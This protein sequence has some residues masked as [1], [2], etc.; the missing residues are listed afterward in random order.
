MSALRSKSYGPSSLP[1]PAAMIVGGMLILLAAVGGWIAADK[2]IADPVVV[3]DEPPLT[4]RTGA[5]E[6]QLRPGWKPEAAL[7][8]L[9]GI[10]EVPGAKALAPTDGSSGRMV[11]ATLPT[12]EVGELPKATVEALRVPLGSS[13]RT[14]VAG[15]RGVG[16]TAL[17]LRGVTAGLADIYTVPTA[18]GVLAVGCVAPIDDPLPVGSCP[19]DIRAIAARQAPPDPAAALKAKLPA[20]MTR[21]NA[22]RAKARS[23]LRAA[24]TAP[25]QA[26]P[27]RR[28]WRA[29]KA[30]AKTL[31]PAAPASGPAAGLPDAFRDAARAYRGLALAAAHHDKRAW[32]RARA[33]V[34]AAEK[35]VAA[36]VNAV[37]NS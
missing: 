36:R 27:A 22:R 18:A 31:A 8:K 4:V 37:R 26:R 2:L 29:Y 1:S 16:Y 11:V 6:L 17:A 9:P 19:G 20:V 25:T 23:A 28:L 5:T 32:T 21:L 13:K 15:V 30:A 14:T 10:A 34:T 35:V 3:P 33:R 12:G 7:P 24:P